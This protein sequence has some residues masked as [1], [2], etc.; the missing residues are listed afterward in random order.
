M[1][2]HTVHTAIAGAMLLTSATT[3]TVAQ[4]ATPEIHL[5]EEAS[6][7][8]GPRA[9]IMRA[10]LPNTGSYVGLAMTCDSAVEVT[11]YL[12]GFPPT[13]APVQL[14]VLTAAGRVERFGPVV[15]NHAGPQS[16][17]HSPQLTNPRDVGR[18]LDA[19]LEN[20]ALVSNGYTSF[21][22]RVTPARNREVRAA[23]RNCGA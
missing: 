12:G 21:W 18:F 16:G 8:G 5:I 4:Q 22:N 20:G 1:T 19:A 17:F 9:W 6:S 10:P 15:V 13:G 14:A 3:A 23:M 7:G 2:A 11:A